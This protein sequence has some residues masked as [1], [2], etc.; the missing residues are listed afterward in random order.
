MLKAE[1]QT[2]VDGVVGGVMVDIFSPD[3]PAFDNGP[4][5][6]LVTDFVDMGPVVIPWDKHTPSVE[7]NYD[8]FCRVNAQVAVVEQ[9]RFECESDLARLNT[10][11]CAVVAEP[12][13]AAAL[14]REYTVLPWGAATRGDRSE[15]E[16]VRD[17]VNAAIIGAIDGVGALFAVDTYAKDLTGLL[18]RWDLAGPAWAAL[19]QSVGA[20][21]VGV[22]LALTGMPVANARGDRDDHPQWA[23]DVYDWTAEQDRALLEGFVGTPERWEKD[24][25]YAAGYV[26]AN[27]ASVLLPTR[28]IGAGL[29]AAGA[30]GRVSALGA[31]LGGLLDDAARVTGAAGRTA[32]EAASGVGRSAGGVLTQISDRLVNVPEAAYAGVVDA[33]HR[34]LPEARVGLHTVAADAPAPVHVPDGGSGLGRVDAPTTGGHG[35]AVDAPTSSGRADVVPERVVTE[36]A[37]ATPDAP[38][39]GA[40]G[41]HPDGVPSVPDVPAVPDAPGGARPGVADGGGSPSGAAVVEGMWQGDRGPGFENSTVPRLGDADGGPGVWDTSARAGDSSGMAYQQFVTGVAPDVVTGR[42]PEYFTPRPEGRPV[43]FD[44]HL[45]RGQPPHEVFLEAK[46]G[47]EKIMFEPWYKGGLKGQMRDWLAAAQRQREAMPP[48]ASLEWHFAEQRVADLMRDAVAGAKLNVDVF[49]TP[50]P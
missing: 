35:G 10:Q 6:F 42:M 29:E 30:A 11:V 16:S 41:L 48:G 18:F 37:L 50:L 33:T 13:S 43:E 1:A 49:F 40:T 15:Y 47:Y 22:P 39:A 20:L 21:A 31:R 7:K 5:G 4:A 44:G 34:A 9:A 28:G 12:V 25:A 32:V 36:P 2:F 24:P 8:L 3:H 38:A 45:W 26:G 27:I 19:G 17:G 23:W 14:N 46:G